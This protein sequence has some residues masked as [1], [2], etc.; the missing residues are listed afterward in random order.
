MKCIAFLDLL[1]IKSIASFSNDLYFK[2]IQSFQRSV[3]ECRFVFGD[4]G[5]KIRVFSDCAYIESDRVPPLLK[6]LQ[7]LRKNLF[8]Q[9]IFFNA[10]VTSGTLGCS[11]HEDE[12]IMCSLFESPDTVKVFSKQSAFSG[13]GIYVDSSLINHKNK[14]MKNNLVKSSYCLYDKDE[15]IYS[16]FERYYDVRYEKNTIPLVRYILMNFT[17][18]ITV[19]KKAAR[20]YLSAICTCINQANFEQLTTQYLPFFFNL[21]VLEDN[22]ALSQNFISIY[23]MLINRLYDSLREFSTLKDNELN[24]ELTK[25]LDGII[26]NSTLKYGLVDIQSISDRIISP[27]NKHYFSEYVSKSIVSHLKEQP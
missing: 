22:Q 15:Y 18:T 25:Y 17:K 6:Y 14:Y 27:K 9:E 4:C 10:A 2:H 21:K 24:R 7:I 5:Y 26:H 13:I 23:Y 11:I 16:S 8:L 20:Y 3:D 1:G 12:K 19:N